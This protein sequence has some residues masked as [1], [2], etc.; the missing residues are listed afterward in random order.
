MQQD[1]PGHELIVRFIIRG[2]WQA[3]RN[4]YQQI[5]EIQNIKTV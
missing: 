5:N 2:S 1:Q 3:N 4:P